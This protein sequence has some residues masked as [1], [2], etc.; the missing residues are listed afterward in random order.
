M[1]CVDIDYLHEFASKIGLHG[2]YFQD[3]VAK[4]KK[5]KR[6]PHYDVRGVFISRALL[7]GAERVTRSELLRFIEQTFYEK[8]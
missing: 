3:K 5:G 2:R 8:V 6:Q 7:E 4:R 1:T